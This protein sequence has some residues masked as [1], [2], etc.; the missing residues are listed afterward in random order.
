MDHWVVMDKHGFVNSY[1]P[2]RPTDST[3]GMASAPKVETLRIPCKS[4]LDFSKGV[5]LN[6]L[7]SW[8]STQRG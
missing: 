4:T 2:E 5:P 8:S 1:G 6:R 7:Y 3:G